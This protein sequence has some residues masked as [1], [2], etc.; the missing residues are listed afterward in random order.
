MRRA[1]SA[2]GE[3]QHD[4][5]T[6]GHVTIDVMDDGSRRAGGAAFYSALQAARLGLR[7]LIITRGRPRE[8]EELLEPFRA[9]LELRV[10][11]A[12]QTTT[13]G[14]SGAGVDRVQRLLAWAGPIP[15]DV[16]VSS[17]VL[18][19]APVA[20]ESPAR[21]LGHARF[22]GLTPQGLAR[23]WRE[24]GSELALATVP[25]IGHVASDC[26]AIVVSEHERASCSVLI[27]SARARG[28]VAAI[29]AGAD[30]AVLLLPDG[31]ALE[32][33]VPVV[34]APR[35]DL[36]AGDVFAAAFFVE[37]ANGCHP[38]RAAR[39]A[40]AAAALRLQ[41]DGAKAIGSRA[42]VE[43]RLRELSASAED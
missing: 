24:R 12:D 8:V 3:L 22:V 4:Y 42:A 40:N 16:A 33:T 31:S 32:V 28:A 41:G 7:T 27:A 14:T 37:L 11:P 2:D 30:P 6:I 17:A 43:S 39:F 35:D 18:H 29:T 23:V 20:R 19:L 34:A 5:T 21:W 26:D 38:E 15:A 36:G 13:L 9:E 1:A 10:L 25:E